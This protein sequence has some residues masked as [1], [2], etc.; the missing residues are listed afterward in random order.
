MS[1][2]QYG[3]TFR[4]A[5]QSE[6]KA[7]SDSIRE[8]RDRMDIVYNNLNHSS[9]ALTIDILSYELKS[10]ACKHKFYIQRAKEMNLTGL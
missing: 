7:V 4:Q 1:Y 6:A 9:D 3:P 5:F 2:E 10:L 8:T